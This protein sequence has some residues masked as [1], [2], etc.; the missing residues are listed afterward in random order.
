MRKAPF[1]PGAGVK[2][3]A[4][5]D[6]HAQYDVSDAVAPSFA[7]RCGR[8][9]ETR[10]LTPVD[11]EI[12]R[13][14]SCGAHVGEAARSCEY[15]GAAV[16]RDMAPRSLICPECY[17]RN[18][19]SSRFCVAC[20]VAF[21]PQPIPTSGRELPCPAC[22]VAMPPAQVAGAPVSE[23]RQCH[24]LWAPGAHFDRL[25][26]RAAEAR[27][28]AGAAAA[29]PRVRRGTPSPEQLRYRKCPECRGFM[30]RRNFRRASGVILDVCREH[31][32]WLDADEI[33][34][35]SG[36]ILSGGAPSSVVDDEHQR[37]NALAA[38]A[39]L[40]IARDPASRTLLGPRRSGLLE[41][42]LDI[43]T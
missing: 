33:E 22:D 15:C 3:V 28:N 34:E 4:C 31:G 16:I 41:L 13:C 10:A 12:H 23:C 43:L 6:C 40:R 29:A 24:G 21:Q 30:L 38:E 20:G 26:E 9:L 1:C 42:L 32:T 19:E 2:L 8:S 25:V 18:T 11:A 5:P 35:I 37:A 27:Q 14:A 36:F 17:A 39:R 7:C